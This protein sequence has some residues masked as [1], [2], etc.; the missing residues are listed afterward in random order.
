[1]STQWLAYQS[2]H[3]SY[4]ILAAINT[5]SIHIKLMMVGKQDI[6]RNEAAEHARETL[7]S[8]F[9]RLETVVHDAEQG[10]TKPIL[11]TDPRLRQLARSFI[12]AKHNWRR[13][14]SEL[15]RNTI[16]HVQQLLWSSE[17]KDRESLIHCLEEL[18]VIIEQH[19]HA[20]AVQILGEI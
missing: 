7:S 15:F 9:K 10:E 20:D 19:V 6:G 8:F 14:R 3:R 1:M 13:Y 16:T 12:E 5:L 2:F 17:G 11:G 18:R 4:D